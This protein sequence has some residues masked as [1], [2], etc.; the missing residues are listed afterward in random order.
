V[1]AAGAATAPA[2]R[3]KRVAS[4]GQQRAAEANVTAAAPRRRQRVAGPSDDDDDGEG[5]NANPAA[6]AAAAAA[7]PPLGG[8]NS[9][10]G[11]VVS[12]DGVLGLQAADGPAIAN[13]T[14]NED[15]AIPTFAGN[16]P[17]TSNDAV[18]DFLAKVP[19]HMVGFALRLLRAAEEARVE[20]GG[21]GS[22]GGGGGSGGGACSSS[23]AGAQQ[24]RADDLPPAA[25]FC[26]MAAA[27]DSA[28]LLA[29]VLDQT[30]GGAALA[31]NRALIQGDG[32]LFALGLGEAFTSFAALLH[33]ADES[34]GGDSAA[35]KAAE[36][37]ARIWG[38]RALDTVEVVVFV[39]P[40]AAGD[41][42]GGNTNEP[43]AFVL[44]YEDGLRFQLRH[45]TV[46]ISRRGG[47]KWRVERVGSVAGANN[48]KRLVELRFFVSRALVRRTH[49]C[50][51]EATGSMMP[52]SVHGLIDMLASAGQ[53]GRRVAL[54][55]FA[56]A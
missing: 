56:G 1:V 12:A 13:A 27:L 31:P 23:N 4:A 41:R 5:D 6:A 49:D 35:A 45:G 48:E 2:R 52:S 36:W 20:L 24:A 19:P 25:F 53:M 47:K 40:A 9:S 18:V 11:I 37:A 46:L 55:M 29:D 17:P 7:S 28:A 10:S 32:L 3:S 21:G 26:K 42:G 50:S 33:G 54:A 16:K 22:S 44:V 51:H 39:D 8:G 43:H 30:S 15:L 38:D 14:P 34:T